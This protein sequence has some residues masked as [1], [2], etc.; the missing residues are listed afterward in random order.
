MSELSRFKIVRY[1]PNTY[2][3]G[4]ELDLASAPELTEAI[5]PSV[6]LGG[7]IVLDVGALTFVD[8]MGVHAIMEAARSLGSNGCLLVHSPQPAVA[9]VFDLVALDAA[10][11]VHVDTCDSDTVPDGWLEWSTP[12]TLAADLE[13]LR[14]LAVRRH[15]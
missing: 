7:S 8:S 12:E 9:R 11:N 13:E 10:P 4:G 14:A 1:G 15:P 3:L 2:F 5:A 6:A